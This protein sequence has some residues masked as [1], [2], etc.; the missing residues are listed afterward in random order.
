MTIANG[1]ENLR[2]R[3]D[4]IDNQLLDL[5]TERSALQQD[6]LAEKI[7]A[8]AEGKIK[9]FRPERER[10]IIDRLIARNKSHPV[11]YTHLTLPTTSRV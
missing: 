5:L 7:K 8:S 11:Y 4:G 6:V 1:L 3:I 2:E 9:I 10:A